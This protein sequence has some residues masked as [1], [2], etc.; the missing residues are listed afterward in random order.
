MNNKNICRTCGQP[1]MEEGIRK[2][3]AT[4]SKEELLRIVRKSKSDVQVAAHFKVSLPTY[5]LWL[6]I[7]NL[8]SV[9]KQALADYGRRVK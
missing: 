8:K 9:E 2:K 6:R 3:Y 7:N 5:K 4:P 1:C